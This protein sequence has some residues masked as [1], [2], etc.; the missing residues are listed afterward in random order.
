[1]TL[2]FGLLLIAVM[3]VR[4][5]LRL[6]GFRLRPWLPA[7]GQYRFYADAL[8]AALILLAVAIGWGFPRSFGMTLSI[9]ILCIAI[10]AVLEW[11]R[12]RDLRRATIRVDQSE[13]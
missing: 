8:I 7:S 11:M 9:A 2:I 3:V 6:A 10:A 4:F 5:L 1:M 12:K 13:I